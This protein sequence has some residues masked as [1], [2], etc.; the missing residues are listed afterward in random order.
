MEVHVAIAVHHV[1]IM[2]LYHRHQL[3]GGG[4]TELHLTDGHIIFWEYL[5]I[6]MPKYQSVHSEQCLETICSNHTNQYLHAQMLILVH[7]EQHVSE[8]TLGN[9]C[10]QIL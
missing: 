3:G 9:L 8:N 6:Y 2:F 1:S 4:V 10:T 7:S 5:K